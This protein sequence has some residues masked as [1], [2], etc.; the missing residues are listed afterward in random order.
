MQW[1][2]SEANKLQA[3]HSIRASLF[4]CGN[5]LLPGFAINWFRVF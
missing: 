1:M 4:V 2:G 5:V 3:P